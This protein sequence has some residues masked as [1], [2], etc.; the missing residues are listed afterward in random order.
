MAK[1]SRASARF[2]LAGHPLELQQAPLL[3]L[4]TTPRLAH[5]RH[6]RPHRKSQLQQ[7]PCSTHDGMKLGHPQIQLPSD[8]EVFFIDCGW[9][10]LQDSGLT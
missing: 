10:S 1:A 6:H 2:L 3:N 5:H 8:M 7:R 9:P 4:F